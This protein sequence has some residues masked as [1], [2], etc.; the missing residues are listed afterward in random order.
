MN[1]GKKLLI[2]TW[3]ALLLALTQLCSIDAL[4]N[5]E[6]MI[7][8]P[9]IQQLSPLEQEQPERG[10]KTSNL[11]VVVPSGRHTLDCK[12]EPGEALMDATDGWNGIPKANEANNA[13]EPIHD[14]GAEH[15]NGFSSPTKNQFIPNI[16]NRIVLEVAFKH[17]LSSC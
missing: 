12:R 6:A 17:S 7:D 2:N 14:L 3:I 16:R 10:I 1:K 5:E 8:L 9:K 11:Q 13:Q 4:A 15:Q